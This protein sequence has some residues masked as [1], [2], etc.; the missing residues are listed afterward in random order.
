VL[1]RKKEIVSKQIPKEKLEEVIG[2]LLK[3]KG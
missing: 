1:N 3:A 2:G